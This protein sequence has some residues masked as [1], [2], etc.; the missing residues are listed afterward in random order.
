MLDLFDV[1][2]IMV[3]FSGGCL[4]DSKCSIVFF[5]QPRVMSVAES[6][7][8]NQMIADTSLSK[9][10]LSSAWL[11]LKKK[12]SLRQPDWADRFYNVARQWIRQ[13]IPENSVQRDLVVQKIL[14]PYFV[15]RLISDAQQFEPSV[16]ECVLRLMFA[17]SPDSVRC[18][19]SKHGERGVMPTIV[20]C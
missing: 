20:E 4:V 2:A 15:P 7:E 12:S 3:N 5:S 14:M 10:L 16:D 13:C 1:F 18:L 6:D 19:S 8:I 11:N 9:F 17:P